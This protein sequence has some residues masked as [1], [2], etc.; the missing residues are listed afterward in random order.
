VASRPTHSPHRALAVAP[1]PAV[2]APPNKRLKLTSLGGRELLRYLAGASPYGARF[3][4][5]SPHVVR[6]LSAIR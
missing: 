3:P 1:D 2:K 6:S 5:A 4:C